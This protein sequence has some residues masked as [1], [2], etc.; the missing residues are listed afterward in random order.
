MD[1][2]DVFLVAL[3]D[4]H[5]HVELALVL[6]AEGLGL[7]LFLGEVARLTPV[8]GNTLCHG[9]VNLPKLF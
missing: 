2:H 9:H 5:L 6:R 7:D 4:V 1:G 8:H 3:V